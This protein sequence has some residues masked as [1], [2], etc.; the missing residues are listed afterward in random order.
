MYIKW[1][2]IEDCKAYSRLRHDRLALARGVLCKSIAFG[3]KLLSPRREVRFE[4]EAQHTDQM[5]ALHRSSPDT[6][7]SLR[8][9]GSSAIMLL[10]SCVGMGTC[11]GEGRQR[12]IR[13]IISP[14]GLRQLLNVSRKHAML[15]HRT[16]NIQTRRGSPCTS[17]CRSLHRISSTSPG[18][19]THKSRRSCAMVVLLEPVVQ[20]ELVRK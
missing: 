1:P 16:S 6:R 20:S 2:S 12:G 9:Y 10:C 11:R 13:F 3:D 8:S 5:P 4:S 14:H 17:R 18:P 7:T 19:S 15:K